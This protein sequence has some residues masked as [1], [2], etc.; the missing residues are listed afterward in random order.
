MVV[1]IDISLFLNKGLFTKIDR[2][3]FHFYERRYD[4]F[5][6]DENILE[7]EWIKNARPKNGELLMEAFE[8]TIQN[9][10]S[11]DITIS[12]Q[13]TVENSIYTI[14]E[15]LFILNNPVCIFLENA[16]NDGNFVLG[17]V[18]KFKSRGRRCLKFINA[19]WL[20][21]KNGGGK[22]DI[23]NQIKN[24]LKLY[25]NRDLDNKVYLRAI[26]IVDSDKKNPSDIVEANNTLQEFCN[27]N[28]ITLHVLEKRE[29]ENYIPIE[30][31]NDIDNINSEKVEALASLNEIQQD[32]YDLDGGFNGKSKNEI[33][34][35]YANLTNEEYNILKNGFS[36]EIKTK[37]EIPK[38]FLSSK[39]T[40][41][42]LNEKCSHQIDSNELLNIIDKIDSLL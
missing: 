33:D 29:M 13:N 2:C 6:D 18:N 27:L 34:R 38:L 32:Y 28:N 23:I 37:T 10:L 12:N 41:E 15:A 42:L 5:L 20:E 3:F 14:D 9:S 39:L 40:H 19:G 11:Y 26:V 1:K 17:L 24:I 16:V 21:L 22:N 4:F 8:R 36:Q 35:I 25:Q 30:M 31:L 7:S